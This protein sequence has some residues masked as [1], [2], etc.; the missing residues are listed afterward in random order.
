MTDSL[1][2]KD[3]SPR[4]FCPGNSPG[5]NTGVGGH[6]LLQ[7]IFPTQRPNPGLL[8]C[9]P[10]TLSH[11]GSPR[12]ILEE[13]NWK[14]FLWK[15]LSWLDVHA[16]S[17]IKSRR[18]PYLCPTK[19]MASWNFLT[20]NHWGWVVPALL[21]ARHVPQTLPRV[22]MVSKNKWPNTAL[23]SRDQWLS[24]G[25]DKQMKMSLRRQSAIVYWK[26]F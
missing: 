22:N 26:M 14:N 21:R 15:S 8:H 9:R 24:H 13:L 12:G 17:G 2:P 23:M 3:C 10:L 1:W 4:L 20:E 11:L 7:G 19:A 5:K 6:F 18:K 16:N 25:V